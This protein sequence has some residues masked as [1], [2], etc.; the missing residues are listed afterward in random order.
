MS[1]LVAARLSGVA[2]RIARIG[3]AQDLS[4][5]APVD[6]R[7]LGLRIRHQVTDRIVLVIRRDLRPDIVIA[8]VHR[9]VI[10]DARQLI[11]QV[12]H[13]RCRSLPGDVF[14][15]SAGRFCIDILVCQAVHARGRR[16]RTRRAM[17]GQE[18][19]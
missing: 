2:D 12:I 6:P 9:G 17:A 13:P 16:S 11:G 3:H 18:A 5:D 8:G 7:D 14:A 19:G 4:I 15:Q 1:L 10:R